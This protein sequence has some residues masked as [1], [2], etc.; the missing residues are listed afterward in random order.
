MPNRSKKYNNT[1][2]YYINT[3]CGKN[4]HFKIYIKYALMG[5]WIICVIYWFTQVFDISS[6]A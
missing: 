6:A 3:K 5:S 4:M 1:E 2:L